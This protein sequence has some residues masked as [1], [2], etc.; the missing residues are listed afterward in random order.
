MMHNLDYDQ[1]FRNRTKKL[2][3]SIIKELSILKYSGDLSVIRKQIYR[4]STSV[5]ANCRAVG[6]ARSEKEKFEKI[7]IVVEEADETQF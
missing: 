5:A 6:R 1:I 4:C 7:C 2:C 3:V